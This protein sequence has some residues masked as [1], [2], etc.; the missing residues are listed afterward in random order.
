[1]KELDISHFTSLKENGSQRRLKYCVFS[2]SKSNHIICYVFEV[3]S[4]FFFASAFVSLFRALLQRGS[5]PVQALVEAVARSSAARLD[6][7]LAMTQVLEAKTLR[8]FGGIH[9]VR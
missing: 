2:I 7:P 5:E 8:H 9:G 3:Y 6:E 4:S 1:M